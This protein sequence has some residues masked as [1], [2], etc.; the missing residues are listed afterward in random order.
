MSYP[1]KEIELLPI[2]VLLEA[3][4]VIAEA[5]KTALPVIA[6]KVPNVYF[7][8]SYYSKKTTFFIL[9]FIIF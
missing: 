1:P 5:P 4:I 6:A 3:V 7:F 9:F 8:G 2:T